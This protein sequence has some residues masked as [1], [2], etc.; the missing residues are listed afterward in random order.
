MRVP[1]WCGPASFEHGPINYFRAR[2]AGGSH[3]RGNDVC[4]RV[5]VDPTKTSDGTRAR[6]RQTSPSGTLQ[7]IHPIRF[8]NLCRWVAERQTRR[9]CPGRHLYTYQQDVCSILAEGRRKRRKSSP[10]DCRCV[11]GAKRD[12]LR[13]ARL[14]GQGPARSS[15]RF[16]RGLSGRIC[17]PLR[18]H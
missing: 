8:E 15:S 16:F 10:S 14:D 17:R 7:R 1:E 6:A 11:F 5:L 2:C 13:A 4:R 9:F 12:R 3:H 18:T